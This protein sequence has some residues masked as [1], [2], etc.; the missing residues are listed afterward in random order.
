MNS[1]NSPNHLHVVRVDVDPTIEE[2]F[3]RWY[4]EVHIPALLA[5]PGWLSA[6]RYVSLEGGPKY[7]AIYEIAGPWVYD[8]PEFLS[9]KGFMEFEPHVSNFMRQRFA[10]LTQGTGREQA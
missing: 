5:C 3:N 8:T 2:A 7:V 10:P 9:C 1:M 6:R 4:E